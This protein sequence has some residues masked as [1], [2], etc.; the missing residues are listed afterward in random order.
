MHITAANEMSLLHEKIAELVTEKRKTKDLQ[1][2]LRNATKDYD[3]LK[4]Q[5]DRSMRKQMLSVGSTGDALSAAAQRPEG[6]AQRSALN[7][8]L[9]PQPRATIGG[10]QKPASFWQ[11]Q[12]SGQ[13]AG[14]NA[15][16]DIQS[17]PMRLGNNGA[18]AAGGGAQSGYTPNNATNHGRFVAGV[19]MPNGGGNGYVDHA[20]HPA[21]QPHGPGQDMHPPSLNSTATGIRG[22]NAQATG[23][24]HSGLNH[25][26]SSRQGG[27]GGG[28][29]GGNFASPM[30][31][32][33]WVQ[34]RPISQNLIRP[35]PTNG[36]RLSSTSE[37]FVNQ[38][39]MSASRAH[40]SGSG[41]TDPLQ[42]P[43]GPSPVGNFLRSAGLR[44][45][46]GGQQPGGTPYR[47]I[48]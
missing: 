22:M 45:G 41:S 39:G 47:P 46:R 13:N 12:S 3:R 44:S 26:S 38:Q 23:G 19:G 15:G 10:T 11:V 48:R 4:A 40:M 36:A 43:R 32:S 14:Q 21:A 8:S 7:Q 17:T 24:A 42:T 6:L 37:G 30:A 16:H 35:I 25:I 9:A 28:G 31:A 29:G 2:A 1:D 5:L 34:P 18:V 27:G 20:N 33:N